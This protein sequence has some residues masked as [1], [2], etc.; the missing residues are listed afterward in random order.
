MF[1]AHFWSNTFQLIE[2]RFSTE[3]EWWGL[4][5]F[6]SILC[7]LI[8]RFRRVSHVCEDTLG[9]L[10]Q[11]KHKAWRDGMFSIFG[12]CAKAFIPSLKHGLITCMYWMFYCWY[13]TSLFFCFF[14]LTTCT[15]MTTRC[16]LTIHRAAPPTSWPMTKGTR[17]CFSYL[18]F[19]R[20]YL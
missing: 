16:F 12:N 11:T 13:Q 17:C 5:F 3:D 10:K 7:A 18:V 6:P 20:R 9:F 19:V 15:G 2:Y 14:L 4:L 8:M 1:R